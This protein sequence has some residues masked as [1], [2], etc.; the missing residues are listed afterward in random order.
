MLE[1]PE[2]TQASCRSYSPSL[3]TMNLWITSISRYLKKSD[4]A[5]EK[6]IIS[7][8]TIDSREYKN[9]ERDANLRSSVVFEMLLHL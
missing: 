6:K 2:N 5:K 7:R 3:T 9:R 8:K 4:Y 1:M